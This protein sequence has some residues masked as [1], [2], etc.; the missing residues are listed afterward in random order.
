MNTAA[1]SKT[2]FKFLGAKLF[3]KLVKANPQIKTDLARYNMTRIE[4]KTFTY[5]SRPQSL[6]IGQAV[7]GVYLN[8]SCSP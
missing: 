3:V 5:S 1:N 4:P 6:S 2:I 8:V 7:T